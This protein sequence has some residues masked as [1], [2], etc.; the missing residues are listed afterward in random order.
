MKKNLQCCVAIAY[1]VAV[2]FWSMPSGIPFASASNHFFGPALRFSGL[3]QSWDMFA[4]T[5]ANEDV[6]VTVNARYPGGGVQTHNISQ[7]S[8][9][10]YYERYSK[11]RWRKWASE[12][13][14]TEQNR[15]MWEPAARFFAK[16]YSTDYP[17]PIS[18]IELVRHWKSIPTGS[19]RHEQV[20]YTLNNPGDTFK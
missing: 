19:E 3:W 15:S 2:F 14:R 6:Y 16:K 10:G 5:P 1:I 17:T 9:M 12:Y 7:M 8:A 11:E 13:L 18:E 20:F 4:P